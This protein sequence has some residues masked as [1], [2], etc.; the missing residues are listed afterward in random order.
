M[1]FSPKQPV[2]GFSMI[3]LRL[4][5]WRGLLAGLF[6]TPC[7]RADVPFITG[8][9]KDACAEAAKA[10]RVVLVDFYTTWCLPCRK[11]DQTT[12]KDKAV[13]AW[14]EKNCVCL[15]V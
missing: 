11:L 5:A 9:F 6:L 14:L 15:K 1:P 8:G 13:L 2:R 7:S 12:W 3:H 10:K 4:L